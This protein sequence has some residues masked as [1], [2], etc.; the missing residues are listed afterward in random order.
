[1]QTR[2]AGPCVRE[3]KAAQHE[4]IQR[5]RPRVRQLASL[6]KETALSSV[7]WGWLQLW[8]EDGL[9]SWKPG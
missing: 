1:M 5:P 2:G 9:S 8:G 3:H 4:A 7:R 6:P